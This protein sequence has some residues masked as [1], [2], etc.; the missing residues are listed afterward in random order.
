M[1]NDFYKLTNSVICV[2]YMQQTLGDDIKTLEHCVWVSL[3]PYGRIEQTPWL[4][5]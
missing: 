5:M 2:L 4:I 1:S 3:G